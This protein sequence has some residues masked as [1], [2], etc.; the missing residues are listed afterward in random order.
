MK[1]TSK[2]KN[3]QG[4]TF[5]RLF[6][7]E[8]VY[9]VKH[10]HR[11]WR[12]LCTCGNTIDLPTNALDTNRTI[13][14]GCYSKEVRKDCNASHR[15]SKSN[16]WKTWAGMRARCKENSKYKAYYYDRGVHVDQRWESYSTFKEDMEDGFIQHIKQFGRRNTSLDRINTNL[17][18]SKENCRWATNVQQICNKRNGMKITSYK[19]LIAFIEEVNKAKGTDLFL[20][21]EDYITISYNCR[22]KLS[23]IEN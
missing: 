20:S 17:G 4:L 14:C 23:K 1:I 9:S 8:S 12:C 13:S 3:L 16:L 21:K 7:Q 5:G 2:L 19:K 10:G 11:I 15:D 22:L 6:V 18:Y